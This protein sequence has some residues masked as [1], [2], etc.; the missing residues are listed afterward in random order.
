MA[1][2]ASA[3]TL[4]LLLVDKY[5][6]VAAVTILI[7]DYILTFQSEVS[8]IWP[9]QWS[10]MKLL[11]F[12]TRYMPIIDTSLILFF[13][14]KPFPT[15]HECEVTYSIAGWFIVIGI[16]IA[17]IILVVRTW[18]IWGRPRKM[19]TCM[20]IISVAFTIPLLYIESVYLSSITFFPN[21]TTSRGCI[22]GSGNAIIA[23]DFILEIAFELLFLILT[24][25]IWIQHYRGANGGGFV[26]VLY[27]DGIFFYIYLLGCSIANFTV[28]VTAPRDSAAIL[29]SLQRILHSCLSARV[30]LNIRDTHKNSID[31]LLSSDFDF[32]TEE[33][34]PIDFQDGTSLPTAVGDP[35][36][37]V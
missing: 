24:L 2:A 15:V 28:V 25:F 9:S 1:T 33:L 23:I 14:F 31:G 19:G 26:S 10:S 12:L 34:M 17:E 4:E 16:M 29:A 20:V 7:W 13:Q 5:T 27:R 18:A 22:P 21:H 3:R 36:Q 32:A 11:F 37:H 6:D 8:L 30:L 35:S